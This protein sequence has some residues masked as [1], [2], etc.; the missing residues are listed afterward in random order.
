M[1]SGSGTSGSTA[2]NNACR[3]R[4]YLT[5]PK[6]D[7]DGEA[8]DAARVLKTMKA[9]YGP[10]SADIE[11]KWDRGVFVRAVQPGDPFHEAEAA[12]LDC[13]DEITRQGRYVSEAKNST[14]YAPKV[15]AKM[16]GLNRKCSGRRL[17]TA[18]EALFTRNVIRVGESART[19][20][21]HTVNGHREGA[22]MTCS[23]CVAL[24]R[25]SKFLN[26]FNAHGQ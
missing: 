16:R 7:E 5:R 8:D 23:R 19:A 24:R 20:D 26:D 11:L 6:G 15:F 14:R 2:W 13:L 18:M 22:A 4:L 10:R 21:R 9:N 3:S 17:A 1:S 25:R 12:F